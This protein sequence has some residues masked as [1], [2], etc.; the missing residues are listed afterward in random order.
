[1]SLYKI[2]NDIMRASQTTKGMQQIE[3]W[4]QHKVAAA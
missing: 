4:I 1:M 2:N 3:Q